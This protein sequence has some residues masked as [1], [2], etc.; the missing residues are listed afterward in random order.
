MPLRR[1]SDHL[2][3]GN[4]DHVVKKLREQGIVKPALQEIKTGG[5]GHRTKDRRPVQIN[6]TEVMYKQLKIISATHGVSV[7]DQI[8]AALEA[9]GYKT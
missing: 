3:I 4:T 9:Q 6:M 2:S 5:A 8:I 7:T 1:A